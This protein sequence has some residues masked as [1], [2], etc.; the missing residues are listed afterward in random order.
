VRA[1][2]AKQ[3]RREYLRDGRPFFAVQPLG[4]YSR[5]RCFA[6]AARTGKQI[7]MTDPLHLDRIPQGLDNGLLPDDIL[8]HLRAEFSGNDLI[9]HE[10]A[11]SRSGD[12]ASHWFT[13]YRCFLPDLAGFS[14]S[15]C[16]AP[17]ISKRWPA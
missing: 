16:A 13:Q 6:H 17:L 11:L 9:V 4:K 14:G 15:N 2:W 1:A 12:T 10:M 5:R 8:K 7:G 3:R